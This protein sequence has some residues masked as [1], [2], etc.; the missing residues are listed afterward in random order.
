VSVFLGEDQI[1][2][3]DDILSGSQNIEVFGFSNL[4]F[5]IYISAILYVSPI[6]SGILLILQKKAGIII[7][8]VQTPFRL[9]LIIQPSIFFIL[10]P[11]N[12][13]LSQS[14]ALWLGFSLVFI[15]EIVK[16]STLAVWNKQRA[17]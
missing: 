1:P 12:E 6:L 11:L 17:A 10:W 8:Y 9:F 14:T 15:S 5:L 16:I 4:T 13:S 7:S 3:V 2:L